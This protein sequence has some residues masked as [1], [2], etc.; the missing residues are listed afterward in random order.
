M[1]APRPQSPQQDG[2]DHGDHQAGQ[3]EEPGEERERRKGGDGLV[4]VEV[5]VHAGDQ[6]AHVLVD[7]GPL[8]VQR[9]GTGVG[10]VVLLGRDRAL[11]DH[12]VAKRDGSGV[13][14][15]DEVQVAGESVD[16][17]R[18][19]V[20][21]ELGDHVAALGCPVEHLKYDGGRCQAYADR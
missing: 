18:G 15:V 20:G 8:G 6:I 10:R 2:G 17:G 13:S 9:D 1:A 5:A 4:V 11:G 12:G 19:H 14:D 3:E 7:R 21:L 16:L